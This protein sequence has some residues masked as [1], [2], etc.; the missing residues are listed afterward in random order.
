MTA[1]ALIQFVGLINYIPTNFGHELD[2]HK[3]NKVGYS[4]SINEHR[5]LDTVTS[6]C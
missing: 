4:R 6:T 1:T 2:K 5:A 3:F